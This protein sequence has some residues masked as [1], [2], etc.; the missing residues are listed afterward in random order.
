MKD[1]SKFNR[2]CKKIRGEFLSLAETNSEATLALLNAVENLL[3]QPT[4]NFNSA[5]FQEFKAVYEATPENV[6]TTFI[7]LTRDLIT[8]FREVSD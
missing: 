5:A 8:A 2:K 4:A 3:N 1:N 6:R 7:G